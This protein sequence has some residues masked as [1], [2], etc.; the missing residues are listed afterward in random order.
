MPL[1]FGPRAQLE[2]PNKEKSF[3]ERAGR[4]YFLT[5]YLPAATLAGSETNGVQPGQDLALCQRE[6]ATRRDDGA[7]TGAD[8]ESALWDGG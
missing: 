2:I 7:C 1:V 4:H 5:G 8:R 3:G 6:R